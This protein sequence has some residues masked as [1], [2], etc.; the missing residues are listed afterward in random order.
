MK[1]NTCLLQILFF[2]FSH[3]ASSFILSSLSSLY[4]RFSSPFTRIIYSVL[5][6][7]CFP[8]DNSGINRVRLQECYPLLSHCYS[9]FLLLF[10]P[11]LLSY[12]CFAL[13]FL[14]LCFP[15]SFYYLSF[16]FIV[17]LPHLCIVVVFLFFTYC[18]FPFVYFI[19]FLFY[20]PLLPCYFPILY[21]L[22][23]VF[24]FFSQCFRWTHARPHNIQKHCDFHIN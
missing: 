7:C 17:L 24:L 14:L 11:S 3:L 9:F 18:C 20:C 6:Y 16:L 21:Y 1:G 22:T 8:L 13:L 12:C 23:I 2:L 19:L 5:S 15:P 4:F 10:S